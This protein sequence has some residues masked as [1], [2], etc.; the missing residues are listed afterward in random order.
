MF[1]VSISLMM[2][3]RSAASQP[4]PVRQAHAKCAPCHAAIYQRY[5]NTPMANV[6]G[7]AMEKLRPG[8]NDPA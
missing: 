8:T 4:T 6:S 3:L 5:L 1:L 7:L 2:M